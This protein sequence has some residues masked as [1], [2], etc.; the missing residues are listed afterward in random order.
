MGQEEVRGLLQR[1][2]F[3]LQDLKLVQRVGAESEGQTW[4]LMVQGRT[5][6]FTKRSPSIIL[7]VP[8]D[9]HTMYGNSSSPCG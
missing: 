2:T 8:H 1:Q 7:F 6:G 5:G 9:N 3:P 4:D